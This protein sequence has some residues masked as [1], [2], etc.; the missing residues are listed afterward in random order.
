[1]RAEGQ[2]GGAAVF[3]AGLFAAGFL[4][5]GARNGAMILILLDTGVRRTELVNLDLADL[6]LEGQRLRV[7]HGK[8]NKQR[9]ALQL[10]QG[11]PRATSHELV[12]VQAPEEGGGEVLL[13]RVFYVVPAWRVRRMVESLSLFTPLRQVEAVR[14]GRYR[15][16]RALP[17]LFWLREG[18]WNATMEIWVHG[19]IQ[20]RLWRYLQSGGGMWGAIFAALL[21]VGALVEFLLFRPEPPPEAAATGPDPRFTSRKEEVDK[22]WRRK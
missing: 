18:G 15:G 16:V 2:S 12:S 7:L 13:L 3:L 11:L 19:G 9:A 22:R 17:D 14:Q 10:L 1:V 20:H 5:L 4:G 6:D 21:G 8:G